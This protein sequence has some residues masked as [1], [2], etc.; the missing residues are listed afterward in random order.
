MSDEDG[1]SEEEH[2]QR[3]S[4]HRRPHD[5]SDSLPEEGE[6]EGSNSEEEGPDSGDKVEQ[7]TKVGVHV[8]A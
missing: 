7:A 3:R 4:C 8:R 5:I 6:T 1:S 2:H